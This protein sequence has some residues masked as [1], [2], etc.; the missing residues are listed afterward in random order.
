MCKKSPQRKGL[1]QDI[2]LGDDEHLLHPSLL[3]TS[4]GHAISV[5]WCRL[6]STAQ[7]DIIEYQYVGNWSL[8]ATLWVLFVY[9]YCSGA[10]GDVEADAHVFFDPRLGESDDAVIQS[11]LV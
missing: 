4:L 3:T 8:L 2:W 6:I 5:A 1:C 9:N 11:W 7:N 10:D